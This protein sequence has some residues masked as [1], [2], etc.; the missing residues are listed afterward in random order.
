VHQRAKKLLKIKRAPEICRPLNWRCGRSQRSGIWLTTI[1][2]EKFNKVRVMVVFVD[3]A[4]NLEVVVNPKDGLFVFCYL[5][6]WF[7]FCLTIVY[8]IAICAAIFV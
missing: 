4:Y 7:S 5:R 6:L 1:F 8:K 3:T 2:Q